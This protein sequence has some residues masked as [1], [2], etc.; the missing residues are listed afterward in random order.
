MEVTV[1]EYK[2]TRKITLDSRSTALIILDM[3]FDFVDPKGSLCVPDARKTIPAILDLIEKARSARAPIIFTQD[4]H[5]ADDPEFSIWPAHTVEGSAGAE[6]M[7]EFSPRK[8]DYFIRKRMY[9]PFFATDLDLLLRQKGIRRLVITGTMANVCVLH[10]AG[11]G[12]LL[13]YESIVPMDAVSALTP[14]DLQSAFRQISFLYQGKL[15]ESSE[16]SFHRS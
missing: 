5:R 1:P 6:L 9:D 14:F 13:G 15:T 8:E 4:W 12:H 16:I 3:Q 11:T 10:T 2:I 7:P